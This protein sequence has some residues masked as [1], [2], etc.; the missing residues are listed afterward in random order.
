VTTATCA[1]CGSEAPTAKMD[2]TG[3]GWRCTACA[4]RSDLAIVQG[5][6][7]GMAEHLTPGE[8]QEVMVQGRQEAM[9]GAVVAVGGVAGTLLTIAS[10]AQIIVVFS[11]AM[12]A[13]FGM[14][15]HGL[16][17]RKQAKAALHHLP[18]ARVITR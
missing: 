14:I 11:G 17:R 13:G 15:G 9:L 5:R 7:A 12:I 1:F 6:P 3:N 18:D 8:L 16:Y 2:M 10:G 4:V